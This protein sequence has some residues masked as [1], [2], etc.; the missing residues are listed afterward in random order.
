MGYCVSAVAA[1][2][3]VLD[4][5]TVHPIEVC[6]DGPLYSDG[7]KWYVERVAQVARQYKV[8]LDMID[9]TDVDDR[10]DPAVAVVLGSHRV[11]TEAWGHSRY[12][13][14]AEQRNLESVPTE[15]FEGLRAA[16]GG[17]DAAAYPVQLLAIM[18]GS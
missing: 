9:L 6:A 16:L 12:F 8:E 13:N 18:H 17:L 14:M 3:L 4:I 7:F 10:S 5:A 15:V 2:G 1:V 11:E